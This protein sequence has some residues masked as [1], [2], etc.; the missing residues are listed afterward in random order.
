MW[1]AAT[2]AAS[3]PWMR[4]LLTNA[5]TRSAVSFPSGLSL[6]HAAKCALRTSANFALGSS[7]HAGAHATAIETIVTRNKR[8]KTLTGRDIIDLGLER[9]TL[10][11][12]CISFGATITFLG[13]IDGTVPP[14]RP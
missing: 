12:Y 9:T 5:L 3:S 13:A 4:A 11:Q 7:A 6:V 1:R 2:A 10:L 14:I 8:L